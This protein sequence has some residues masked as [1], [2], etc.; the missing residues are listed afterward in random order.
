MCIFL[1]EMLAKTN[2]EVDFH[3][4]LFAGDLLLLFALDLLARRSAFCI[5]STHQRSKYS[6]R[7]AEVVKPRRLGQQN[8][9]HLFILHTLI[10]RF[11][12]GS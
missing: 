6:N 2:L 11:S 4:L 5:Q 10:P 7:G 12:K 3:P 9:I 8:L 1:Q